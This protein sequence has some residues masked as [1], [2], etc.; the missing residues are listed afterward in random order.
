VRV[1]YPITGFTAAKQLGST[2]R[3]ADRWRHFDRCCP[4]SDI[5]IGNRRLP[6]WV[7]DHVS[8]FLVMTTAPPSTA[9]ARTNFFIDVIIVVQS[10][11]RPTFFVATTMTFFSITTIEQLINETKI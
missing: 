7:D 3:S 2:L 4:L 6:A 11:E 9:K 10:I 5:R 1:P 8:G